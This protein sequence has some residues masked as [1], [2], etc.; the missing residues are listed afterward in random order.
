MLR[1]D[2][3]PRDA[4]ANS[5]EGQVREMIELA[6]RL[7]QSRGGSLDDDSAL[8]ISE[9]TGAPLD[10]VR[11]AISA[12]ATH[13][14]RKGLRA[15]LQALLTSL[16]PD[17]R[18]HVVGGLLG[19]VAGVPTAFGSV[20]ADPS[21]ALG[22]V[23]ILAGLGALWN[24]ALARRSAVAALSGAAFGTMFFI[25]RTLVF[26]MASFTMRPF[27]NS[28]W[29]L[30]PI[31][32]GCALGGLLS[33]Q[34]FR[35]HAKKLVGA[36][37]SERQE[38][39]RQLVELKQQLTSGQRSVTFLSLDVVGS[40]AMKAA[41]DPLDV[42]FTFNEYHRYVEAVAARYGGVVHSTAGDGMTVAFD[43]PADAFGAAKSIQAGLIEL[44]TYRN[45]IGRPLRLRAAVH[46]GDVMTPEA[47]IQSLNFAHV[48][49]VA[50]HL[51]KACPEGCVVVS[52][53]AASLLEGGTDAV[54]AESVD[55]HGVSGRVWR[56]RATIEA[57]PPSG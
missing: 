48:I 21:G 6:W 22:L 40:T 42:E 9:V 52:A 8:A 46:H 3:E 50:A 13:S 53:A 18:R 27:V 16:A 12:S 51:Q 30:L 5:S 19:V 35:S 29:L 32:I 23:A 20:F 24:A 37:A 56:P 36:P 25:S 1:H 44:N 54:G 31:A 49:D 41:A 33:F 2:E 39:L 57:L 43:R 34:L 45:R 47:D 10:L 7:R 4:R 26:L 11:V 15:R 55:A 14:P 17:V 28:P 38:L